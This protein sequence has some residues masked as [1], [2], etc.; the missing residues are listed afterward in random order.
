MAT[1]LRRAIRKYLLEHL[2]RASVQSHLEGDITVAV[3]KVGFASLDIFAQTLAGMVA[4]VAPADPFLLLSK[5]EGAHSYIVRFATQGMRAAF[6]GVQS[7]PLHLDR[8]QARIKA[9]EEAG[10]L[11][12]VTVTPA[13]PAGEETQASQAPARDLQAQEVDQA[14]QHA[15]ELL[16]EV[17]ELALSPAAMLEAAKA[18]RAGRKGSGRGR[19]KRAGK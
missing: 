4:T 14:S 12:A 10:I 3:R 2:D 9:A 15:P 7:T 11:A 5:S 13:A 1:L 19:G 18:K 16:Q 6:K 17:P 8:L